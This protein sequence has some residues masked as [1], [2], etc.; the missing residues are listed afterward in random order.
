MGAWSP[1]HR[2]PIN[3]MVSIDIPTVNCGWSNDWHLYHLLLIVYR[4]EGFIPCNITV[5]EVMH[6][7]Y[8]LHKQCQIN[9]VLTQNE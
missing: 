6:A 5:P 2:H 8:F 9:S 3:S 4:Q 7:I 1:C